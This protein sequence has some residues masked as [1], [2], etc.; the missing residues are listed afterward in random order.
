MVGVTGPSLLLQPVAVRGKNKPATTRP[1]IN[2]RNMQRTPVSKRLAVDGHDHTVLDAAEVHKGDPMDIGRD[3]ERGTIAETEIN[4]VV[5]ATAEAVPVVDIVAGLPTP[6]GVV[7][8]A[9]P[10]DAGDA[11][12]N[13]ARAPPGDE[14]AG[15]L[16]E[17]DGVAGPVGDLRHA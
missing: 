5:V 16:A 4:Y 1:A 11:V 13:A 3:T 10:G 14:A 7:K 17:H 15:H 8:A 6:A 12:R 9:H 2:L